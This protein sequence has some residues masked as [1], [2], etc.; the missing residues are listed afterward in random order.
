MAEGGD[1]PDIGTDNSIIP[2]DEDFRLAGLNITEPFEPGGQSTPHHG[3]EQIPMQNMQ[4]E[5]PGGLPSYEEETSFGGNEKTP[6]L[7]NLES[8][9]DK[10]KRNSLTGLLDISS[11]PVGENLLSL[12]EQKQEIENAKRFIKNRY[13]NVDFKKLGPIVFSKKKPLELVVLGPKGGETPLLLKDGSDLVKSALNKTF[14]KNALGPRGDE[15]FSKMSEDI[16]KRQKEL[17]KKRQ[18]DA[19]YFEM[20]EAKEKEELELKRRLEL[21]AAKKSQLEDDPNSDKQEIKRKDLLIKNLEK[22]LKAKQKENN[23]LQKNYEDSQ[24]KTEKIGQLETSIADEEQK[25]NLLERRFNS[26]RSFDALK[27]QEGHLIRL[28]EED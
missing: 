18:S 28:N 6:L 17:A 16:R 10:L 26:T 27:E 24:K 12:E 7:S 4:Q 13:P 19:R 22:D 14:I 9:L 15:L 20:K 8:R 11:I 5:K 2:N 23:Q 1:L 3:H 21:E 25:R